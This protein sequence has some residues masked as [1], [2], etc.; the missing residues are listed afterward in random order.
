MRKPRTYQLPEGKKYQKNEKTKIVSYSQYSKWK[1]CPRSWKLAYIDK[2][3]K[4]EPSIHAVFGTA[5]HESIQDWLKVMYEESVKASDE[6]IFEDL[7]LE[8]LQD[9]Y[10][11]E[12]E[13]Y[14]QH[15]S[16][17]EELAEFYSDGLA[18]LDWIRK[19]RTHWFSTKDMR[20]AGIEVPILI[21][22]DPKKPD[23]ALMGF[24]DLVFYDEYDDMFV[25][26]DIKTSK[27]G[28]RKWDKEDKVKA[29]QVVLYKIY[30]SEQFGIP[31]DKIRVEYFIV[32]RKI[33][34]D[35]EFPQRRVQI[36]KPSQGS[37]TMNRV[38]REFQKF[39]DTCFTE[40]GEYNTNTEYPAVCGDKM[41]NCKF[42]EYNNEEDCPIKNRKFEI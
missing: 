26:P 21:P 12:Y 29:S 25:I 13:S 36:F 11:K 38:K 3:K 9:T 2:K 4:Y 18:I 30:L 27:Q 19:K 35:S 22:P 1:K 37:V 16:N 33:D 10:K 31:V 32:K 23:V 42:C 34:E 17:K 15:F 28:W 41:W 5:M 40:D 7:L 20:L 14:G 24:L 8:K 39:L 6:I